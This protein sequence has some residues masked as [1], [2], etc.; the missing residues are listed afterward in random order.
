[1]KS[2]PRLRLWF[3][4]F[5][6]IFT[7]SAGLS[8]ITPHYGGVDEKM[9]FIYLYNV[10][11]GDI[12]MESPIEAVPSWILEADSACWAFNGHQSA[13]CAGEVDASHVSPAATATSAA[14]YPPLYYL[15]VGWPI[16]FF[17]GTAALRAARILSSVL[18]AALAALGLA[19]VRTKNTRFRMDL[20]ALVTITPAAYAFSGFVQPQAMEIGAAIALIGL[21]LPLRFVPEEA[22]L[23]LVWAIPI[24]FLL[25][26]S[27]P[28]GMW[29]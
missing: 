14:N 6:L 20:L 22:R 2:R 8:L 7:I 23:R 26:A 15:L 27:R 3:L 13:R 18:F 11:D 1:M 17:S 19:F 28:T 25:V 21:L 16:K 12:P 4:Y 29:W 9:H 24:T 5:F 10:L